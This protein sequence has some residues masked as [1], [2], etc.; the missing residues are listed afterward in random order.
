MIEA[1][2]V[3]SMRIGFA[4]VLPRALPGALV[5]GALSALAVR[6]DAA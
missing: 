2:G 6:S 1:S 5:I 4:L 3:N